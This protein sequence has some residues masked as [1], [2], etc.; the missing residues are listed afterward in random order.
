MGLVLAVIIG[1]LV[2]A[3][4]I[5]HFASPWY[6]TELASN[7]QGID[8]TVDI[9]FWVTGFV[10]V[11]VNAFFIF[12]IYKYRHRPGHKADYDPENSKLEYILTG[13]TTI[14]VIAML[15]PGLFTWA[16][17][18]N[19]PE[20]TR[21]I[22]AVGK[23]WHWS[24]RLAGADGEFGASDVRFM[25]VDNPFGV[26]PEDPAGQDDKLVMAPIL[27]LPVDEGAHM[28]LRSTDVLHN[29]TVPQFR[30]KMDLVPGMVTF[31]WFTPTVPGTYDVLCEE[32]C[33]VGHFAMRSKV[34]VQSRSDFD[35]WVAAQPT[36]AD[37]QARP[38]GN[39][40]AGAGTY[41]VCSACHGAQGEGNQALMAPKIAGSSGWYIRHQIANYQRGIRGAD[42]ADAAGMTMRPMSMTLTTPA[43]LEN[44]IAYIETLP[45][46]RPMATISG[47]AERGRVLYQS[48]AVCHGEDGMGNWNT[49]AP[50]LAGMSDWY[51]A[52]QLVNFK[53]RVRG[54]HD[55][56][57]YG[58]QMYMI[59]SSLADDNAVN[60][61]V[62]YINTL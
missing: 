46:N 50:R 47:D 5:F 18:V 13:I 45:D 36:F 11:A 24:Y 51:L 3:S 38:A 12:C 14:G 60:D 32:H 48:C 30:V 39:A 62:A 22:E 20:G 2:I 53:S 1:L 7:W 52:N 16:E 54:G 19:V 58:D 28:L 29:F 23:Q 26:D 55:E 8:T 17:F 25:N 27:H 15:A 35:A 41:A 9:T 6:F 49:N 40:A 61:V 42:P 59:A 43:L 21:Q 57:V 34:V 33:G 4:V 56:D 44:V 31:Q 37:T 10:F